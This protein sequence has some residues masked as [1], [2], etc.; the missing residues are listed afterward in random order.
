MTFTGARFFCEY[1]GGIPVPKLTKTYTLEAVTTNTIFAYTT[2][3]PSDPG[4][5]V[6]L[7]DQSR[8]FCPVKLPADFD[9]DCRVDF[10]D[11]AIFCLDWLQC[12]AQPPETCW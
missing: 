11:F 10:R 7:A 3:L 5:F 12:T 8:R 6:L 4:I 1:T 9:R 2:Y